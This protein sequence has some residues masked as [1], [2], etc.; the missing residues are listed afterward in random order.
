MF[1][2]ERMYCTPQGGAKDTCIHKESASES[3]SGY[4]YDIRLPKRTKKIK[5][6]NQIR[7][8]VNISQYITTE[9]TLTTTK[10][11]HKNNV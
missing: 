4:F 1:K 8:H 10:F 5:I 11:V 9:K 7:E 6:E 3:V 2:T